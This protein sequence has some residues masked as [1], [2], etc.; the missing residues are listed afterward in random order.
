VAAPIRFGQ[1]ARNLD[2]CA[3]KCTSRFFA[4]SLH[5]LHG[6]RFAVPGTTCFMSNVWHVEGVTLTANC[7][8][9]R[10]I[11]FVHSQWTIFLFPDKLLPFKRTYFAEI[12]FFYYVTKD[13]HISVLGVAYYNFLI[14]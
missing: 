6:T 7:R 2:D 11:L 4:V 8:Q 12:I 9:Q 13:L 5:G 14:V 3:K 1:H 10:W